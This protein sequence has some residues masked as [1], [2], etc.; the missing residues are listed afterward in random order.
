MKQPKRKFACLKC[1]KYYSYLCIDRRICKE[2]KRGNV[3][4]DVK[5]H[6]G[7]D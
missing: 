6:D 4:L 3:A 7:W 5:I 2:C 1:Q